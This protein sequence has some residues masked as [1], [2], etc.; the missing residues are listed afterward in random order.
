MNGSK[1]SVNDFDFL[2]SDLFSKLSITEGYNNR[3]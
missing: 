1:N 3:L 2:K